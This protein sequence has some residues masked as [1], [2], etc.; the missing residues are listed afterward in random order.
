VYGNQLQTCSMPVASFIP[1]TM[2]DKTREGQFS[3]GFK[4]CACRWGYCKVSKLSRPAV[5]FEEV[6]TAENQMSLPFLDQLPASVQAR[7]R[8][9]AQ[10]MTFK[11]GDVVLQGLVPSTHFHVIVKGI[12][13]ICSKGADG[14]RRRR[15][16]TRARRGRRA[17]RRRRFRPNRHGRLGRRCQKGLIHRQHD[18]AQKDREENT[19]LHTRLLTL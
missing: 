14:R 17:G 8:E 13:R 5:Q 16:G 3:S 9:R 18:E 1:I 2:Q 12:I 7:F 19:L 15:H 6:L 4:A 11:P 10:V